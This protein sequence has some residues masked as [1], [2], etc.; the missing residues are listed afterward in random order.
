[1]RLLDPSRAR[2]TLW[3]DYLRPSARPPLTHPSLEV[4][5]TRSA[6]DLSLKMLIVLATGLAA[7]SSM[8]CLRVTR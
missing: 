2:V 4:L 8:A 7:G 5:R 1:M 3:S 6:N